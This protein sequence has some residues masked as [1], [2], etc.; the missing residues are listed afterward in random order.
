[1]VAHACKYDFDPITS[2]KMYYCPA[3]DAWF[4]TLELCEEHLE[5]YGPQPIVEFGE[6]CVHKTP[7]PRSGD[8]L[9]GQVLGYLS[10][11]LFW[12]DTEGKCRFIDQ[13]WPFEFFPLADVDNFFI[14]IFV[15]HYNTNSQKQYNRGADQGNKFHN[16][17]FGWID[18]AKTSLLGTIDDTKK[19]IENKLIY[20]IKAQ[21][22][23]KIEPAINDLL[24]KINVAENKI[25]SE[26]EPAVNEIKSKMSSAESAIKDVESRINDAVGRVSN[27]ESTVETTVQ[28]VNNAQAEIDTAIHN[29]E[30]RMSELES[31]SNTLTDSM[32]D[33]QKKM[34]TARNTIERH[35]QNIASLLER[36]KELEEKTRGQDSYIDWIKRR[37]GGLV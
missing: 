13:L 9:L 19:K 35:T 3:C 6:Y 25:A 30:S 14:D 24:S 4:G 28:K 36:V 7:T 8:T 26:I 5:A 2:R 17:I 31:R 16:A 33:L 27:M 23:T 1:M 29:F 22:R 18:D 34:D 37:L 20:P 21:I 32:N 11:L 10:E 15:K 12:A